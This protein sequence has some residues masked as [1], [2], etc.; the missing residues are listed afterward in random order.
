MTRPLARTLKGLWI[1]AR[2]MLI[3]TVLLGIAYPAIVTAIGGIAFPT[4][5][6][7]SLL[8]APDGGVVG[9]SLIGQSF[10][11]ADGAPLPQ[12]V[13]P[14]PS[15]AG[16]GYDPRASGGSNL[17][18]ESS[19]LVAEIEERRAAIAAFN[20]VPESAIPADAVTAS[21]SGLDPHISPAYAQLQARR[22]A[23]ARGLPLRTVLALIAEHTT[24][25]DLGFL[26]EPR[27]NV[28]EL[29]LA[30]DAESGVR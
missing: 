3:F 6:S 23:Q 24:G 17:G 20:G 1:S 2:L 19:D 10:L 15:A 11:D 28:V 16:E 7:G 9:S 12:Y 21:A 29:D 25:R 13:Q 18:P 27:V 8:R 14:R 5:A 30:L 22:V 4:Q 26:G